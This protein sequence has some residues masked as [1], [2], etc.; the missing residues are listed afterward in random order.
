MIPIEKMSFTKTIID[1]F[2]KQDIMIIKT[3]NVSM[4]NTDILIYY[5][6]I[7]KLLK[8]IFLTQKMLIIFIVYLILNTI[9]N[10]MTD[11]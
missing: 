2:R 5:H 7:L 4:G 6:N 1:W 3:P 9:S 11:F 8:K 10:Q